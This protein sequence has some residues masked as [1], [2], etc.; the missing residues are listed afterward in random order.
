MTKVFQQA[1]SLQV[2][3]RF[4]HAA[5]CLADTDLAGIV[6]GME[7]GELQLTGTVL[8]GVTIT[9][10]FSSGLQQL[11]VGARDANSVPWA[12][13]KPAVKKLDSAGWVVP[14]A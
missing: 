4:A 9:L 3:S 8:P 1:P 5:Q 7:P 10:P 6:G 12:E 14:V 11:P 2:A 13:L